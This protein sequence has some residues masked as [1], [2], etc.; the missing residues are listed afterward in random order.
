MRD[1]ISCQTPMEADCLF[2]FYKPSISKNIFLT[3]IFQMKYSVYHISKIDIL[4]ILKFRHQITICKT[5]YI[6]I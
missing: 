4:N 5:K 2:F 1:E 3:N 6:K